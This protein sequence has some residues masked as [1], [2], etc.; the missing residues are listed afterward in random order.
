MTQESKPEAT[1]ERQPKLTGIKSVGIIGGGP[2]GI[3]TLYELTRTLKD[4]AISFKTKSAKE[5]E[6]KKLGAFEN[7]VLFERHP[8]VGGVWSLSSS[9]L[10]NVDPPLPDFNVVKKDWEHFENIY[11]KPDFSKDGL[12]EKLKDSSFEKPVN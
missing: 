7:V 10:K 12:E 8:T 9:G 5:I 4:G 3:A 6:D 1:L 2:S 11:V